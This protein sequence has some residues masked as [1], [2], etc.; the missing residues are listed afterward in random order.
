MTTSN[1]PSLTFDS[2]ITGDGVVSLEESQKTLTIS[3]KVSGSAKVGDRIRL[4]INGV[5]LVTSVRAD[6]TFIFYV[7]G[8]ELF[9]DSSR[10]IEATL[11]SRNSTGQMQTATIKQ[12]Y[13]IQ[14]TP[15]APKSIIVFDALAKDNLIDM[16]E[17]EGK[18]SVSGYVKGEFRVGQSVNLF[19]NNKNYQATINQNGGFSTDIAGT[20][21]WRDSD[22]KI[23]AKL[24]YDGSISTQ[25]AYHGFKAVTGTDATSME[26]RPVRAETEYFIQSLLY[27]T[28]QGYL[29][30][31]SKW[32]GV[33]NGIELAYTFSTKAGDS[34][35]FTYAEQQKQAVREALNEYSTFANIRFREVYKDED[36]DFKFYLKSFKSE[37]NE[38]SVSNGATMCLCCGGM[39]RQAQADN[40]QGEKFTAG[41][42]Y[43]GGDVYI[44][45]DIYA[46]TS[47]SLS[48]ETEKVYINKEKTRYVSSGYSTVVHEI[49]HSLGLK[50]PG[51]YN[52]TGR[53]PDGP[54][55]PTP[56]ENKAHSVMSY[57]TS[58]ETT[59]KGMQIFDIATI[60]YR[61]GVNA[62]QR[63]GNDVYR[64]QKFDG[65]VTGN[66]IYIW[67][68]AGVDTFD[69][70]SETQAVTVDLTP[71]SWIFSGQKTENL[72]TLD[73]GIKTTGQAFIGYGTQIENLKGSAFNDVLKGNS[74][75]NMIYGGAGNDKIDGGDG[76]DLL[77]GGM[78]VD[79]LSG[80]K[81]NDNYI[82]DNLSDIIMESI[83][84]GVDTVFSSVNYTLGNHIENLTLVGQAINATGNALNNVLTGNALNNT[85]KG[86]LGDDTYVFEGAFGQDVID[87]SGGGKDTVAFKG[88]R[89]EQ[90]IH[91][92][93]T[94]LKRSGDDL[95]LSVL[96]TTDSVTVKDWFKA[97][98]NKVQSFQFDGNRSVSATEM[99]SLLSQSANQLIQAMASFSADKSAV[100]DS[101]SATNQA[102]NAPVLAT[103]AFV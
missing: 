14:D 5:S 86:G 55:L 60:H 87:N 7:R 34:N 35:Y 46:S 18:I 6:N 49:G 56:E 53:L 102:T 28:E 47:D 57:L 1:L 10:M 51:N 26:K 76:N 90:V 25:Y 67:D 66:N 79:T 50:H 95:L 20:E 29:T 101:I 100:S 65:S 43:L 81:G 68:G 97:S 103:S 84:E 91:S 99:D 16:N 2:K 44:N 64:F 15:L 82:V 58:A 36:S 31:A 83:N 75:D 27:T 62:T 32:S 21:L 37:A 80:G 78:G 11:Y 93:N 85:L 30:Q 63:S 61:Y 96:H 4:K 59:G 38:I 71:G 45:G 70:S 9:K 8:S 88:I 52:A 69:A 54:F 23:D 13:A 72:V 3:G 19:I 89:Y 22:H 98:V 73:G 39:C 40:K 77:D 48:K 94:S 17:A 74:A 41:Y 24:A 42:A 33:G 92:G 12:S